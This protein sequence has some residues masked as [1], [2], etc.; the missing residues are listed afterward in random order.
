MPAVNIQKRRCEHQHSS[1]GLR[2]GG[3]CGAAESV[4]MATFS[5]ETHEGQISA[6]G[7]KPVRPTL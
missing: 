1:F 7:E 4:Q 5:A 6:I 3:W 2:A